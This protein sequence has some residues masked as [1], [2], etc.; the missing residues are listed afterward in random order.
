M[1]VGGGYVCTKLKSWSK[2]KVNRENLQAAWSFK[3][4]LKWAIKITGC[5]LITDCRA[6][7]KVMG[8]GVAKPDPQEKQR[9]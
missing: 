4:K 7:A 5:S 2:S 6:R 9:Q 8:E 1:C 3:T